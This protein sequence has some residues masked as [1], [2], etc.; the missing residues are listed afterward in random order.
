MKLIK[1]FKKIFFSIFL[2]GFIFPIT[3][4]SQ[5]NYEKL[6]E[7]NYYIE[8]KETELIKKRSLDL[9]FNVSTSVIKGTGWVWKKSG[10]YYYIATNLHVAKY[11]SYI[12]NIFINDKGE[13]ENF[14]NIKNFTSKIGYATSN[15]NNIEA[16]ISV[17]NPTIVYTTLM[18]DEFNKNINGDTPQYFIGENPYYGISDICILRYYFP[19]N[20]ENFSSETKENQ[21]SYKNFIRDWIS[22]FDENEIQIYDGN[23]INLSDYAFYSGGFPRVE[24]NKTKWEPISDF[25]LNNQITN[26]ATPL[27]NKLK[28]PNNEYGTSSSLITYVDKNYKQNKDI[29]DNN[30]TLQSWYT[31]YLNISYTGYFYAHSDEGASGSMLVTKM[32]DKLY[33]VGIY[34][35]IS[36]FKVGD[37]LKELGSFDIFVTEKY[38]I[39]KEANDIILKDIADISTNQENI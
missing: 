10:D 34:W 12:G 26:Y 7:K 36:E 25:T 35:G 17:S 14:S 15:S 39:V 2:V 31:N 1:L 19:T 28:T 24:Q 5:I 38:N 18:D 3:S 20:E 4:C 6:Y 8:T 29:T 27:Y 33:I 9:I 37:N 30:Y 32:D 16:E 13:T 23:V 11:L 22:I 21:S